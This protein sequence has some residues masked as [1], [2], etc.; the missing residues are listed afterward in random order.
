MT[1]RFWTMLVVVSYWY[2]IWTR[3]SLAWPRLCCALS[4]ISGTSQIGD[5][6]VQQLSHLARRRHAVAAPEGHAVGVG[7]ADVDHA[8]KRRLWRELHRP[9]QGHLFDEQ[10]GEGHRQ[11]PWRKVGA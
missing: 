10:L 1:V 11:S 3:P 5:R 7:D 8:G 4:A 9:P 6:L 2:S